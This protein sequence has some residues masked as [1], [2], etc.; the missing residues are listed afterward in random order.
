MHRASR[1]GKMPTHSGVSANHG[2]THTRGTSTECMC[3]GLP[4]LG[5]H[6]AHAS[7]SYGLQHDVFVLLG[8][9]QGSVPALHIPLSNFWPPH[10]QTHISQGTKMQQSGTALQSVQ[11]VVYKCKESISSNPPFLATVWH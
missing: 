6:T 1:H 11:K 9:I 2:D 4:I 3:K 8:L 10:W 7:G 5:C